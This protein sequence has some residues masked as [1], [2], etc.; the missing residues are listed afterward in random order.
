MLHTFIG[1]DLDEVREIVREP[2]SN[3]LRSS[4][5]LLRHSA[6]SLGR[7]LDS[8]E[9]SEDD[10]QAVLAH[11]FERYF[12]TSAL[13]G[14]PE[15]CVQMIEQLKVIGVDEVGCLLDFGVKHSVVLASLPHLNTLKERSNRKESVSGE[16][17]SLAAQIKKHRVTHLQCTPSMARLLL[18]DPESVEAMK[19]LTALIVGGDTLSAALAN[20]LREVLPGQIHNMYGPTETTIWSTTDRV[21]EISNNVA[22]GTPVA[23]TVIYILDS[24]GQPTPIGVP[25]EIFIGGTGVT[26]GYLH[27]PGHSA[28]KFVPDPFSDKPGGRLYR[29]GDRARY[30]PDGRIEFLGRNDNQVKIRGHRVEV[31]EIEAALRRHPGVRDAV[32]TAR[33]DGSDEKRLLAYVVPAP[34]ESPADGNGASLSTSK[35]R[36]Y[37]QSKLPAHMIPSVITFL[38]EMPLTPNGKVDRRS[39]PDPT[40]LEP[41][42]E[43]A[44]VAPATKAEQTIASIWSEVL[45]VERVGIGENFFEVGGTSMLIVQVNS[46]LREAF[47]RNIPIFE[48]F[49]HPTIDGLASFIEKDE[50]EKP[51]FEHAQ[52]R[53]GRQAEALKQQRQLAQAQRAVRPLQGTR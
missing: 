50:S 53:A 26:R 48:M 46:K 18:A 20:Q 28:E 7:D 21:E 19:Q 6:R 24:F 15:S 10:M 30:L 8:K 40:S 17:Y 3:Y 38:Q 29:T 9:I 34:G 33:E 12:E 31:G 44:Y 25:G 23:N 52:T 45:K 47:N 51:S 16:N 1:E 43:A 36:S 41:E 4:I 14:T 2:F 49:R 5:S 27:R 13:L 11:A 37:L 39:F 22:I 35:L 32:I 42:L